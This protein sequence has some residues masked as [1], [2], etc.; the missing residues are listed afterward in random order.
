MT[1][2]YPLSWPD[3][4]PRTQAAYRQESK[5]RFK[6]SSG[7]FWTLREALSALNDELDRLGATDMVLS[8]NYKRRLDGS[9]VLNEGSPSDPGVA[10]YFKL[11]CTP[12]VMA[13]DMHARAEENIRSIT[14]AIEAMRALERHGGGLMMERAFTGFDALPAPGSTPWWQV[15]KVSPDATLDQIEASFRRLAHE[16]HPDR[17]GSDAMMADLNAARDEARKARTP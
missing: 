17:G 14:L 11:K 4:W 9:P 3:G 8:S 1:T 16:C 12:K 13:C 5:Y 10:V 15:L 2:A 7:Q 6:R